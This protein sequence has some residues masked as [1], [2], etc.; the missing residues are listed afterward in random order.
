IAHRRSLQGHLIQ[1]TKRHRELCQDLRDA[2]F[3]SCFQKFSG[4][5][6]AISLAA[7]TGRERDCGVLPDLGSS[8]REVEVIEQTC[9]ETRGN[10]KQGS[11][12][13]L[14][15]KCDNVIG[16]RAR[17]REWLRDTF[18]DAPWLLLTQLQSFPG[19]IQLHSTVL[20]SLE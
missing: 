19:Q 3:G 10:Y 14:P 9:H 20:W 15:G 5:Y 17:S 4:K 8:W 13:G 1:Q 7:Y 6:V 16:F 18:L 2:D 12:R 11:G